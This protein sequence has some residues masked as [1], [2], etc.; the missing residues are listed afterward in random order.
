MLKGVRNEVDGH[1]AL[2]AAVETLDFRLGLV[3]GDDVAAEG[4]H[5]L[6]L[7]GLITGGTNKN[8]E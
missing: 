5:A 2:L 1:V 8:L 7:D 4:V 6:L 3:F